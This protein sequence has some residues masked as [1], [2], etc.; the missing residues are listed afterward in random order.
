ML[1]WPTT[2]FNCYITEILEKCDCKFMPWCSHASI[3]ITNSTD[4]L[5]CTAHT[6]GSTF[7]TFPLQ[8]TY[9]ANEYS[10]MNA[11][12]AAGLSLLLFLPGN[13]P[14]CELTLTKL[15]TQVHLCRFHHRSHL[16][17]IIWKFAYKA[18]QAKLYLFYALSWL[19]VL[20]CFLSKS[21]KCKLNSN[22]L[23]MIYNSMCPW[24]KWSARHQAW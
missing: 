19:E 20:L 16:K 13:L 1:I 7:I 12:G 8:T 9:T 2:D 21:V 3:Q 18:A 17:F 6:P 11:D 23:A 14:S 10:E 4:P 24:L 15:C 5:K 22:D